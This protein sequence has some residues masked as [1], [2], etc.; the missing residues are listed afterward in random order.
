MTE[1][2][3]KT[4]LQINGFETPP[5]FSH[6]PPRIR[7]DFNLPHGSEFIR[8]IDSVPIMT[9]EARRG[10]SAEVAREIAAEGYNSTE[11]TYY[12][13]LGLRVPAVGRNGRLPPPDYIG[14][15]AANGADINVLKEIADDLYDTPVYA[16]KAYIGEASESLPAGRDSHPGAPIKKKK[17]GHFGMPEEIP[18]AAVSRTGQPIESLFNRIEEKTGIRTASK[19]GSAQGL[20]VHVFGK[21]AAAM[22]MPTPAFNS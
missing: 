22:L 8:P 9:A 6:L 14:I 15:T 17:G 11:K 13:G 16:D 19:V 1:Q 3:T 10:G 4:K 18:S 5:F 12:Y 7:S 2:Y 21:P 20:P